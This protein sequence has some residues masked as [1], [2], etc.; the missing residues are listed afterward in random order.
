VKC[1][2]EP[3]VA[4]SARVESAISE[5]QALQELILSG[6][7]DPRVLSDFRDALNR[8]RNTAWAAQQFVA[9]QLSDQGSAG[10]V[11]LLASERIRAVYQLSR[12]L[13]EDLGNDGIQFQ[14][15]QLSELYGVVTQLTEQLR[16][17]L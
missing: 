3:S 11:S 12:A 6:D 17:R 14:K 13:H 5:L 7:L 2:S 4:V 9:S 16:E 1:E 10:V 15:G 8:V